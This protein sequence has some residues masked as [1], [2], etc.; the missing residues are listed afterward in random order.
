MSFRALLHAY[1]PAFLFVLTF[2]ENIGLPLPSEV[3]L[4]AAGILAGTGNLSL[5]ASI[6]GVLAGGAVGAA[7]S[8]WIGARAGTAWLFRLSR[9]LG[10]SEEQTRRTEAWFQEKGYVAVFLGRFLPFIRC[11]VGYPAGMA[12]MPFGRYMAYS[13]VGYGV[14][15]VGSLL[16]GYATGGALQLRVVRQYAYLWQEVVLAALALVV[17]YGLWRWRRSRPGRGA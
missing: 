8:Y 15:A 16:F 10:V 5:P 13:L 9:R 11:L 1:G 12:R 14:W 17:L 3:T 2:L 7:T 6:I 4:I